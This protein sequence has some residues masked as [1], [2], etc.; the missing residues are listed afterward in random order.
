MS[1][2]YSQ[3]IDTDV[4]GLIVTI[5][6]NLSTLPY[7]SF[8]KLGAG[9]K[10]TAISI[11]DPIFTEIEYLNLNEIK[12]TFSGTFKGHFRGLAGDET[13]LQADILDVQEDVNF[14]YERLKAFPSDSKFKQINALRDAQHSDLSAR[15]DALSTA[16]TS[17]KNRVD[18]L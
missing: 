13:D 7:V 6:H 3:Y 16:L 11:Y 1:R 10:L 17:L 5:T 12:V 15:V 14:L 4:N 2:V 9:D 18:S 8:V